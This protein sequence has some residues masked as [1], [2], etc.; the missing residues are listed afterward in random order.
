M[1]RVRGTVKWWNNAKGV[2]VSHANGGVDV[3]I[4]YSAIQGDGFRT[5]EESE[6]VEFEVIDGPKGPQAGNVVR[7]G[8]ARPEEEPQSE[9]AIE[10]PHL[11]LAL[12]GSH[13]R[14]VSLTKDGA[15]TFL[16]SADQRYGILYV[17][18][19]ETLALQRAVQE[20]EDLVNERDVKEADLQAFFERNPDFV[21]G[22][23][24]KQAH[25][26]VIL[27]AGSVSGPL[28]PDFMLEPLDCGGFADLLELKLPSA[29][30]FV[31]KKNRL[32]FSAAV[33]EAVA[34]AREYGAFFDEEANRKTVQD[35]LGFT[36]YRPRLFV[37]I[38]RKSAANP[39][40]ARRADVDLPGRLSLRTYDDI[41]ARMRFR[42]ERMK[43]GGT[44]R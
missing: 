5:L 15:Y 8:V 3:F 41:L 37:I 39:L 26:H 4:H 12:A 30:V 38:G 25:P 9:L 32:R 40:E 14:L 18:S 43:H 10:V 20:F 17:A 23:E 24:Y 35:R 34:Q 21:L 44:T 22:D 13:V 31:L 29:Q 28:V 19:S 2:R 7:L 6:Q 16:D 27:E 36:A 1:M 11:A 33:V 42:V